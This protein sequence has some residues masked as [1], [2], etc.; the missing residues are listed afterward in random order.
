M[1]VQ[2]LPM[3][4]CAIVL[5]LFSIFAVVAFAQTSGTLHGRVT[6]P[7]GAVIP[8]AKVTATGADGKPASAITS[9]QGTYEFKALA[10]GSYNVT[11]TATGFAVDQEADVKVI[12]GQPQELDI[13][14]DR[15]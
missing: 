3:R 12:A 2:Y 5:F 9:H 4:L 14:L 6:D 13:G 1:K 8:G 15:G 7:S 11:A 10:P